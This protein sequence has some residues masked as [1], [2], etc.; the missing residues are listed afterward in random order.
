[1]TEE[2]QDDWNLCVKFAVYA[3]NSA[4]HSTV[5]LSSIEL[6]MGRKL[7]HPNELLRRTEVRET[8]DLQNYHEQLLVAME[9]SHEC[10]E[11]ARQREQDRQARYYN[12]K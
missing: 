7:R 2:R 4:R 5:T 11:L 12:R 10:A 1:M 3:Y 6:M 9:R 8:G